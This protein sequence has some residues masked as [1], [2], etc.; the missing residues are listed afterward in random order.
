MFQS[1]SQ[2]AEASSIILKGKDFEVS[3]PNSKNVLWQYHETKTAKTLDFA[4]PVFEIDGKIMDCEL[5][6]IQK[7]DEPIKL[8]IGVTEYIVQGAFKQIPD[9]F[10][11]IT[12]RIPDSNPVL[13]FRYELV[14]MGNHQLTKS[15]GSDNIRYLSVSVPEFSKI[16]E[17]KLSEFNEM[18]H[19]F[20]LWEREM[21]VRNFNNQTSF[22]G[23]IAT[24][25]DSGYSFLVAYEHG[26]QAPDLFL[27]YTLSPDN[28][29]ALNAVKGNYA[30]RFPVTKENSYQSVWFETAFIQG[31]EDLLAENYRQFILRNMS[32]NS[33]S[34]KP[35]KPGR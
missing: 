13:R 17:V 9:L 5:S 29:I 15:G 35:G 11:R 22:M 27:K 26:S 33:E 7:I 19:S 8:N 31:N 28:T 34:R 2:I 1:Y 10:L 12:F 4:G 3:F 16:K 23:P 32:P 21:D 18:V 6:D 24:G 25:S 20:C 14:G 30:S